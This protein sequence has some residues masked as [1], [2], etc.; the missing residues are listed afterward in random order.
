[1]A[2]KADTF[3]GPAVGL[4]AY[5]C[6]CHLNSLLIRFKSLSAHIFLFKI[7]YSTR[8]FICQ[9]RDIKLDYMIIEYIYNVKPATQA[10]AL[11]GTP[12]ALSLQD[13]HE[14]LEKLDVVCFADDHQYIIFLYD[15]V[16]I[17]LHADIPVMF[18]GYDIE[19]V[20]LPYF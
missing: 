7:Q 12:A 16:G 14:I 10:S 8:Y 1:M 4:Y 15:I 3:Q 18:N 13:L 20:I 2:E 11:P 17:D 9:L 6:L 19:P 5:R